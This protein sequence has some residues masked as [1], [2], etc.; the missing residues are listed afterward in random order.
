MCRCRP[1]EAIHQTRAASPRR[2]RGSPRFLKDEL[3]AA[4]RK[5]LEL[6]PDLAAL[7]RA[8][9]TLTAAE[10]QSLLQ[11]VLQYQKQLN[12]FSRK[13]RESEMK[14]EHIWKEYEYYLERSRRLE[15]ELAGSDEG[16]RER[17]PG[18]NKKV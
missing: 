8:G 9:H 18:S 15:S 11:A 7:I 10:A 17:K 5:E 16:V 6:E 1:A 13:S 12:E 4:F 14:L 3:E 2:P